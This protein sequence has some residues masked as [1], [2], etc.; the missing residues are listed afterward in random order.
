VRVAER[1]LWWRVLHEVLLLGALWMVY[2]LGRALAGRHVGSAGDHA[3]DVWRLERDLRLPDEARLQ[4]WA[5]GHDRLI[6]LANTYYKWEHWVALGAVALWLLVARPERYPWFRA[7]L[8]TVTALALAGH[9]AYPLMPPRMRP[10]LGIVDTG[11]RYG[12]SVYGADYANSGLLNQYAA[13]PSMHVGWA[14]LFALTVVLVARSR[15]RWL[16][17]AYPLLTLYVVVV[18][19]NHYWLD[20]VVGV[21]LLAVAV[22]AVRS[23]P[24]RR[25]ARS[26]VD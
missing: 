26:G 25:P 9:V 7:V 12:Q 10:D 18:T 4:G 14:A 17:A 15:W 1:V 21:L 6:Q 24:V 16:V 11:V 19:G 13:M 23:V 22:A 3:T 8:I 5:L 2:T 20:G